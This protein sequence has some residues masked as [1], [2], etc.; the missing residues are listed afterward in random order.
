[1]QYGLEYSR[2]VDYYVSSFT[3]FLRWKTN[4][5]KVSYFFP[6]CVRI[7][8][9]SYP[10]SFYWERSIWTPR[11]YWVLFSL[12]RISQN[13]NFK[14]AVES[15]TARAGYCNAVRTSMSVV[16]FVPNSSFTEPVE[17]S[18][19]RYLRTCRD[20]FSDKS[21]EAIG[22]E[23]AVGGTGGS[24]LR[25]ELFLSHHTTQQPLSMVM[26]LLL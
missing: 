9:L 7:P 8:Q 15:A 6:V 26:A 16:C 23:A 21:A 11:Y 22:A 25:H 24:A 17:Y 18:S 3:H 13:I 10:N 19:K 20:Y 5:N 2:P 1:M 12:Y 14:V 4:D